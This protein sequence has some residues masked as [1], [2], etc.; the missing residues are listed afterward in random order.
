M[1]ELNPIP[2]GARPVAP[3]ALLHEAERQRFW[4]LAGRVIVG[5]LLL[6]GL[7]LLWWG[8]QRVSATQREHLATETQLSKLTQLVDGLELRWNAGE[9]NRTLEQVAAIEERLLNG[10]P[11]LEAWI[12]GMKDQIGSLGYQPEV[13]FQAATSAKLGSAEAPILPTTVRMVA[14]PYAVQGV[15]SYQRLLRFYRHLLTQPKRV[16]LVE[17]SVGGRSNSVAQATA[18]FTIWGRPASGATPEPGK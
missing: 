18:I 5:V 2:D 15:T 13:S 7:G 11:A 17:L 16:D 3:G 10:E 12:G 6:A 1:S 4:T 14:Q 9:T 8:L